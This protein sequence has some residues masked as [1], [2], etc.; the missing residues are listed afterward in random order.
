[1]NSP[2][3]RRYYRLIGPNGCWETNNFSNLLPDKNNHLQA[4]FKI[5]RNVKLA[6]VDQMRPLD[7]E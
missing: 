7:P 3:T 4:L 2:S 6:Y 5:G 1:M